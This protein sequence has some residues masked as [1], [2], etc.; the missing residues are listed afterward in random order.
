MAKKS[1]VHTQLQSGIKRDWCT[2][3]KAYATT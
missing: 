2:C 3:I 1:N